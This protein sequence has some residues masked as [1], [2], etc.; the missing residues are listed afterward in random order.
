MSS[1]RSQSNDRVMMKKRA[2]KHGLW[3]AAALLS[4]SLIACGSDATDNT[5]TIAGDTSGTELTDTTASDTSVD[6]TT[7]T[8]GSTTETETTVPSEF[9][10][11]PL[12]LE[13]YE[14]MFPE[15]QEFETI[16]RN[17]TDA[18]PGLSVSYGV[19]VANEKNGELLA[20]AAEVSVLDRGYPIAIRVTHTFPKAGALA[21]KIVD[22]N[23][24][25]VYS[26]SVTG[27]ANETVT[28]ERG[29]KGHATGYFKLIAGDKTQAYVVTPPLKDRTLTDS[30]F[31]ADFASYHLVKNSE[32]VYRLS[33]AARL[34]GITWVR[35][36]ANWSD[37]EKTAGGYDFSSTETFYKEID[38]SG[39]NILA[40]LTSS[41]KWSK[42][43]MPVTD[44]SAGGFFGTQLEAYKMAKAMTE[45]Y[46]GIVDAWE[47]AN[48]PE[49]NIV[50]TAEIYASW[51]KAAA[52]GVYDADH[53]MTIS[54]AGV[55]LPDSHMNF[56]HLLLQNDVMRYTSIFNYHQHFVQND[57]IPNYATLFMN[58]EVVS[59]LALYGATDKPV[60]I[61]ESGM[62]M[63]KRD[64]TDLLRAQ[65]PYTVTSTI[66]SLAIGTDKH[67]WFVLSPYWENGDFGTFSPNMEPYPSVAAEAVMTDVMGEAKYLGELSDLP[68]G[69]YGYLFKNGKR[70]VSVVW[71]A[72]AT[73]YTFETAGPVIVTTM[74]GD[75]TLVNPVDGKI[76]VEIGGDPIYITYSNP[77]ASYYKQALTETEVKPIEITEADRVII[78][79]EFEAYNKTSKTEGHIIADGTKINVRVTNLN[80]YAV[81]GTVSLAI[82]GFTVE[83]ASKEITVAAL[84]EGFI[85]LTLKKTDSASFDDFVVV[86]GTFNGKETSKATFHARTENAAEE[87]VEFSF[88]S[89]ELD[90]TYTTSILGRFEVM[91]KNASGTAEVRLN[92]TVWD[93]VEFK[94][95]KISVDLRDID[96]GKYVIT[97]A[98]RTEGGDYDFM[99]VVMRYDGEN[100]IFTEF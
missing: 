3:V 33:A 2:I 37:Y 82:P 43:E 52:L 68:E 15:Y 77:P 75:E 9:D 74:M 21:Y 92:E 86:T 59:S 35:E 78:T 42:T 29:I 85:T 98:V 28:I 76:T 60:W 81:T 56:T 79:P 54:M 14:D 66:Q 22:L 99:K 84:S 61:T 73:T 39:L 32:D 55:C 89:I 13:T 23:G 87:A 58:R 48:E 31:G 64:D 27:D 49:Q 25:V 94:N 69:A 70:A 26:G 67:F 6:E 7:A 16:T 38:R 51:Y 96:A 72:K 45:Y 1:V 5:D 12:S 57:S 80:D 65:V 63:A 10:T 40:M 95:G 97:V 19:S 30:P 83:G 90:K 4:I 11:T 17:V 62:V 50:D 71:S 46:K 47:L 88:R 34:M 53:N 24:K 20:A 93:K 91:V 44:G 8:D 36:R 100:V 18:T 41:P